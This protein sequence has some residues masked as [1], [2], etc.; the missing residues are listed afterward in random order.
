MSPVAPIAD[1]LGKLIRMLSSD[2][3][4]E[5]VAAVHAI[6]RTLNGGK[7][8]IHDLAE[9]LA[10]G[11]AKFTE[12][13]AEEIYRRGKA[14]GRREADRDGEFRSVDEPTWNEIAR[15]CKAASER[16]SEREQKFVS[17]MVRWTVRDGKP[18]EKQ[19]NWRAIYARVKR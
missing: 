13:D 18:T 7:L 15:E 1:K 6:R 3:D 5:V 19:A 10:G 9:G 11:G 8:T 4:G 2:R 14:D 16:L 17:D 12:Q